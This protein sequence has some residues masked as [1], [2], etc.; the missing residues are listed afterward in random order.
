MKNTTEVL[1]K[2]EAS[3]AAVDRLLIHLDQLNHDAQTLSESIATL[4]ND[5]AEILASDKAADKRLKPLLEVRAK[6]SLAEAD[7]AKIRN[8]ISALQSDLRTVG[9]K[10]NL[11]VGAL[12]D[13]LTVARRNR[14]TELLK[15][16]FIDRVIKELELLAV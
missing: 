12:I 14:V 8:E 16:I 10:A 15:G 11:F 4:Q 5:E 1:T 3:I 2:A 7:L 6:L 13:A 9:D